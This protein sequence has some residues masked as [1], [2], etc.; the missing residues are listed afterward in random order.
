MTEKEALQQLVLRFSDFDMWELCKK[1]EI[2]SWFL[3]A[4][5]KQEYFTEADLRRCLQYLHV[6]HSI[7]LLP[8]QIQKCRNIVSTGYRKF[9]L[10]YRVRD[11][12]DKQLQTSPR[13]AAIHELLK[14]LPAKIPIAEEKEYLIETLKCYQIGANRAAIVMAWN[15]AFSHLCNFILKDQNK[16]AAFNQ[17]LQ[18]IPKARPIAAYDDYSR[19][20]E[21][22]ILDIC[23][24][25]KVI[26]KNHY[27]ILKDKLNRRNIAAHPSAVII[28]RIDTEQYI[29]DVINNLVLPLHIP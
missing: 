21:S 3:H 8:G 24:S 5:M 18:K 16:L 13:A 1:L 6:S 17:E 4:V 2:I 26:S 10:H 14:T 19:L 23:N 9:N 7:Y 28:T 15:L 25:A 12:L 11:K 29:V 22:I 27:T 20:K